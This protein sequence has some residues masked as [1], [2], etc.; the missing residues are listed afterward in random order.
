MFIYS[1]FKNK[2][3]I[4]QDNIKRVLFFSLMSYI[5]LIEWNGGYSE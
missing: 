5:V 1:N 4:I 3:K 2:N